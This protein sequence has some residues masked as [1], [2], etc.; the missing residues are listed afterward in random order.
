MDAAR[1]LYNEVLFPKRKADVSLGTSA[2]G[3]RSLKYFNKRSWSKAFLRHK[4]YNCAVIDVSVFTTPDA[5]VATVKGKNSADYF[6]RRCEKMGYTFQAM[7]PNTHWQSIYDINHSS[8]N[9][10]GKTMDASYLNP[11]ERWPN[12]EV[13]RWYGVFDNSHNLVAYLWSVH[14]KDLMLINRVLGHDDHLKNNIMYFLSVRF[15]MECVCS[16]AARYV[17]YDT[18]GRGDNGLALFKRRIG[19]QHYRMNF[20]A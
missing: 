5:Y 4:R 3:L 1:M 10:Q 13:N 14:M 6:A 20:T 12:D 2:E 15:V 7:D 8:Q 19:F 17:M 18:F 11:L 16:K 9:R